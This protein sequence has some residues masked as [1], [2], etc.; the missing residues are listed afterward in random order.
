M[1]I[2]IHFGTLRNYASFMLT[3]LECTNRSVDVRYDSSDSTIS[4]AFLNQTDTSIKSCSVNYGPCGQQQSQTTVSG[5]STVASPNTVTLS[6]KPRG[7]F[8]YTVSASNRDF[9]IEID[10]RI[11]ITQSKQLI[12]FS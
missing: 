2:C 4:C 10:G 3:I 9:T 1:Y 5:M 8:C 12:S 11:S 7:T 6:I